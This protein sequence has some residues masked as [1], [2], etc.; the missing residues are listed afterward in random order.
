MVLLFNNRNIK[1]YQLRHFIALKEW[2]RS[3]CRLHS[4]AN[5]V[6]GLLI[7]FEPFEADNLPSQSAILKLGVRYLIGC[8]LT[9]AQ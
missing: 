5:P 3:F 4:K 1:L 8:Q 2:I 9:N 6:I 7:A